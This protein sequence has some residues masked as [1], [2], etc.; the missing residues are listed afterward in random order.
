M[1]LVDADA[2][3]H[4]LRYNNAVV[5]QTPEITIMEFLSGAPKVECRNCESWNE[6]RSDGWGCCESDEL[7]YRNNFD[8]QMGGSF[9]CPF[10]KLQSN[11]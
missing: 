1:K 11:L 6:A 8:T 3:I 10:Y 2:L 9:G 7:S 4:F 5:Y